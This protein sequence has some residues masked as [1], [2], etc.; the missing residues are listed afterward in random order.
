MTSRAGDL[1]YYNGTPVR[2]GGGGWLLILAAVVVAFFQLAV[3]QPESVLLAYISALLLPVLPVVALMAAT[4]W[5]APAVFRP[6]G[7]TGVLIA[8]GFA[9][10]TILCS[11]AAGILLARIMP[12]TS[13]PNLAGIA[14]E[15]TAELLIFL[16]RAGVQLVGEELVTILPLLAVLWVCVERL[17]LPRVWALVIAVTVSTVWFAALHLPTYDWN[18]V[19]CLGTIGTARIVLTLAYLVTRNLWVSSIAHIANDWSLFF[20][21]FV[22]HAPVGT[23]EFL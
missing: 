4:G 14:D 15:G 10:L 12:M 17:K 22:G 7:F 9:L 5:R 21:A 23:E 2:I 8:L 20:I 16:G 1:P 19:Q 18:W 3:W 13:N 6:V 11:F